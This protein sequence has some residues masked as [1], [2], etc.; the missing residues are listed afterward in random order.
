MTQDSNAILTLCSHICVGEGV[1][2]L[3]PK[4]YS[5]LVMLLTQA[6]KTPKDLFHFS[7]EDFSVVLNFDVTQTAR[8]MRLL[9]R[10]AS[11]SFELGKYQNMG[12]TAITRADAMYPKVLKKKLLNACPPIFY[13]AGDLA[14]LE[15][16]FIGYVGSRT[17]VQE[18]LD[19]TV[20]TVRKTVALGFGVVSGGAKGIDTV[21]G[22]E[23]LL[24]GG[25]SVEFLSDSLLKKLKKSDVIR[26]IQQGKLLMLSVAKPDAGFNVGIAMMRNRY[27]YAQSAGTVIVRSDLNKG[28]TW[29]GANENLKHNWCTA[30]CW[31]HPYPGNQALIKS[32][33]IP[34]G[35]DWNGIVPEQGKKTTATETYEQASLFDMG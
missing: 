6:G 7:A 28:G 20:H 15:R 10:N 35:E 25:I 16:Q 31:D 14:L 27:I 9:D 18:D 17:I 5:D 1:R 8:F 12:I 19:F 24:H 11:L 33:A 29:T 21:A 4:E 26:N 34:I 23:A 13:Y 2:P 22:T 32:G 3:E 30:L